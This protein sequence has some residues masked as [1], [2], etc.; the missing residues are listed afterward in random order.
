MC[1]CFC[2]HTN[3]C[4]CI[5]IFMHKCAEQGTCA[6][7][8]MY[9]QCFCTYI[10]V[11]EIMHTHAQISMH[12][13]IFMFVYVHT[14]PCMHTQLHVNVTMYSACMHMQSCV[15]MCI[16]YLYVGRCTYL[17]ADVRLRLH[18][19]VHTCIGARVYVMS[20]CIFVHASVHSCVCVCL[21]SVEDKDCISLSD[22]FSM[23]SASQKT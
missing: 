16:L 8:H 2:M 5:Y 13:C 12:K 11:Q 4:A 21:C 9:I 3:V 15:C 19:Y 17:Y 22:P 1:T 7:M 20:K 10:Y 6:H 14:R 23:L 18:L